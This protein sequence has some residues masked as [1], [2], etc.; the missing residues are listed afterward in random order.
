MKGMRAARFIL[1]GFAFSYGLP[2]ACGTGGVVGGKCR[3][4]FTSC[5]GDCNDLKT[6]IKSCGSCGNECPD[7]LACVQGLCGGEDGAVTLPTGGAS[8]AGGQSGEGGN[9]AVAGGELP[10]GGFLDAPVDGQ[11]DAEPPIECLPPHDEPS[12]CGDCDTVCAEPTPFCAPAAAGGFECV[13]MCMAPLV[14]CQNQCLDPITFNSDPENCGSCGNECPSDICQ[15]GECVGASFGNQVLLCTNFASTTQ[16]SAPTTLLGNVIF[17]PP[18]NPVNVMAYTRGALAGSVAKVNQVIGWAGAERGRTAKITE[19]KTKESVTANLSIKDYSVFLIHDLSE[20]QPGEAEAVGSSWLSG[21]V[22]SSFA[23]AGGVVV[24]L[25]GGG[26]RA[27]MHELISSAELLNVTGQTNISGSQVWNQAPSNAV[28]T[29]VLSP[30]LGT[31][32]TCTFQTTDA[33]DATTFFVLADQKSG[34]EPVV[35][36]RVVEPP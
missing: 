3:S 28:G 22:L 33:P 30:F 13:P 36:H 20:A 12:H 18:K 6:D 35:I 32:R 15:D 34:G 31:A 11:A 5:N 25:N 14:E 7:D 19:A 2:A 23:G 16:N 10:D 26:G 4:G 17:L 24:V 27:E 29:N 1:L 21:S 8:S 9:G